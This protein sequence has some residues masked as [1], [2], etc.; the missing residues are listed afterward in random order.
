MDTTKLNIKSR[1]M[2][3]YKIPSDN[4]SENDLNGPEEPKVER[5]IPDFIY[6]DHGPQDDAHKIGATP[7]DPRQMFGSIETMTRGRHPFYL[8]LLAFLGTFVMIFLSVIVFAVALVFIALSLLFVRQST[9][10]N[11]QARVAWKF[12]KK[13]M[14]FTLGCFVCIFNMSF[15]IGIV[16]MYFMLTGEKLS[17][18]FVQE[19]SKQQDKK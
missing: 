11:E 16:L 9:Y 7:Q 10:M 4:D 19:F 1:H 18:R 2:P 17:N 3:S 13:A 12:F 5:K 14:V 8:R 6:V 15:G